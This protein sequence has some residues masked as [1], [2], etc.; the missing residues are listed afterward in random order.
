[1]AERIDILLDDNNDVQVKDGDFVVGNSDNQNVELLFLANKADWK[2]NPMIGIGINE[3]IKGHM[4]TEVRRNIDVG[5][6]ADGYKARSITIN[7][8]I[9]QIDV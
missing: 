4:T 3:M 7:N 1:M 8:G 2:Q 9:V 5:L 6:S